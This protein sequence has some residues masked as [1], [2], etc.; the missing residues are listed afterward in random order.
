[1]LL[2]LHETS[3]KIEASQFNIYT[4]KLCYGA[5][6]ECLNSCYKISL[7]L[8]AHVSAYFDNEC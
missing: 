1:M 3:Q 8:S 6:C 2:S 4:W 7:V 5:V